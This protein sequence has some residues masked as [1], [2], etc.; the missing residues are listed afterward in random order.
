MGRLLRWPFPPLGMLFPA[1]QPHELLSLLPLTQGLGGLLS[2]RDPFGLPQRKDARTSLLLFPHPSLGDR[3]GR[4]PQLSSRTAS[5]RAL[6]KSVLFL[7]SLATGPSP[8]GDVAMAWHNL[9]QQEK[10]PSVKGKQMGCKEI[11]GLAQVP[12]VCLGHRN[13]PCVI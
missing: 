12:S 2:S 13:G 9:V 10:L 6:R 1:P 4:K 11:A 8:Q 7:L 5:A 3:G